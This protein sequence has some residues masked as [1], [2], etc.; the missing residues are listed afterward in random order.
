L[1]DTWSSM[2]SEKAPSSP[3]KH[4]A[5]WTGALMLVWGGS[6]S[7]GA[8][9]RYDPVADAWTPMST[10]GAPWGR[11]RHSAVW[12]GDRMIVWGGFDSR[13]QSMLN[14]GGQYDPD[15]DTWSPTSPSNAATPRA[16][17][18]A[19]WTGSQMLVWGGRDGTSLLEDGARYDPARDTWSPITD[20]A[21]PT[22]LVRRSAVWTGKAMLVWGGE[23]DAGSESAGSPGRG[24]RYDP[25]ADTWTEITSVGAPSPRGDHV[26]IWTGEQ[27]AIWD[28]GDDKSPATGALYDP[29]ADAW[30]PMS[31][32]GAPSPRRLAAAAWTGELMVVWGGIGGRKN[33]NTGGRYSPATDSWTPTSTRNVPAPRRGH[34]A[35]WTGNRMIVWGGA[36][37]RMN[38]NTGGRYDPLTDAWS[39][40]S[41]LDAPAAGWGQT[42]VWAGDVM[43]VWGG[44]DH[45]FTQN[46]RR[47]GGRYDPVG[48]AW[49]PVSEVGAPDT[50]MAHTAIWTG[51]VMVVWGGMTGREHPMT[52]GARYDP[53]KDSWSPVST[54]GAPSPRF[55]HTAVWTGRL[56]V[57][58]GGETHLRAGLD[59]L[60]ARY[61]PVLDT[62][63]SMAT[64]SAPTRA[65]HAA[66][67]T[68]SRMLVWGESAPG[69]SYDPVAD[70]WI[71]M[72]SSMA[73]QPTEFQ[74]V[75][76]GDRM[77]V[78]GWDLSSRERGE[79]G[80]GGQY[81]PASN[82]WRPI[83]TLGAPT[84]RYGYTAVWTGESMVIWGGLQWRSNE[85]SR[86]VRYLPGATRPQVSVLKFLADGRTLT[87]PNSGAGTLRS[88]VRGLLSEL[89][90][91]RGAAETCLLSKSTDRSLV[92]RTVP[93]VGAG[94][95]YL[96]KT[97]NA[98]GV[99]PFGEA[100]N[101]APRVTSACP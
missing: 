4:T 25:K 43:I 6:G 99:E 62:W 39:P 86:G 44:V 32:T 26:A 64:S 101:G 13:T 82:T 57:V 58:W 74:V 47:I 27:M 67:W 61:D 12:T 85:H 20:R 70:V 79:V 90:V 71:R 88:V 48:D 36:V 17:H 24:G 8:G 42:A 11:S 7:T 37:G 23:R 51:K 54:A 29:D 3:D 63:T 35:V 14:T 15:T 93:P 34:T 31:A 41:T 100:S 56:M 75:W 81:F 46:S 10:D 97:E 94:F 18:T 98:C 2:S 68:G 28:G 53:A 22:H 45:A 16:D 30:T 92:D 59:K 73:S 1:I 76:A 69:A 55:S 5:V 9:G 83:T 60:G 91:G 87:W 65:S 50:R 21:A 96:L 80:V 19:V 66:V 49:L 95:W 77:L 40:T 89:P 72:S 38:L 33:L 84:Q 52:T 78:W